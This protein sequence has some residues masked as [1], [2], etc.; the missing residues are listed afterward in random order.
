MRLI[1][2]DELLAYIEELNEESKYAII[3]LIKDSPTEYEP[4]YGKFEKIMAPH[5]VFPTWMCSNCKNVHY[6]EPPENVRYCPGCGATMDLE[7]EM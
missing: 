2:A 4:K 1:D 3:K 7:V 6:L 5:R